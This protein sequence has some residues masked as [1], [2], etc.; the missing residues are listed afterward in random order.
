MCAEEAWREGT[1]VLDC[2]CELDGESDK[3]NLFLGLVLLGNKSLATPTFGLA[4]LDKP[5]ALVI[6]QALGG[7]EWT[8]GLKVRGS[9]LR[10]LCMMTS[11]SGLGPTPEVKSC[12]LSKLESAEGVPEE[13]VEMFVMLEVAVMLLKTVLEP[14]PR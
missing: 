3:V 11:S 4:S 8:S 6:L 5:R 2:D 14:R 7:V 10:P 1:E 13:A 9:D 12:P